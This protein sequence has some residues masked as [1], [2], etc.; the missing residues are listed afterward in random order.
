MSK[1]YVDVA[2]EHQIGSLSIDMS[3]A[4]HAQWTVL[5]GPS[6]SGKSTALRAIAG[7]VVPD[8]GRISVFGETVSNSEIRLYKAPA[9]R[10]IRWAGQRTALFPRKTVRWNLAMGMGKDE[11]FSGRLWIDELERA[12]EVFRLETLADKYPAEL[13]GGERQKVSIVRAAIGARR[14]IL[15]LDEPFSGLDADVREDVIE[16]L[17]LW[18]GGTPILSV[19]HDVGEAFL[20]NAEIVK[21]SEGRIVQQGPVATVLADERARLLAQLT[22]AE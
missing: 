10:A 1:P 15:L 16:S 12:I 18:L 8:R 13:S 21:L 17:Q 11:E 19:T 6:G 5:F 22:P 20:L 4:V 3:F 14:K 7:L 2:I 9:Q